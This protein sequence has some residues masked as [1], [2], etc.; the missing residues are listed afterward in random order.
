MNDE[1]LVSMG[2]LAIAVF[3]YFLLRRIGTSAGRQY[4]QEIE[5]ILTSE[6]Y[7]VKGRFG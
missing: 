5:R 3:V 4:E 1:I 7:K 2:V 6:E